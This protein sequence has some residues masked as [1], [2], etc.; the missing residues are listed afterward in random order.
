MRRLLVFTVG[1]SIA[2]SASAA[3]PI[4]QAEHADSETVFITLTTLRNC[5]ITLAPLGAVPTDWNTWVSAHIVNGSPASTSFAKRS[6]DAA[7]AYA[8]PQAKAMICQRAEQG[9][10]QMYADA[11]A[12]M[13][14][15]KADHAK[16]HG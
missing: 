14:R 10:P 8:N 4:V 12:A 11:K 13:S 1:A 6:A 7:R 15:L 16:Y 5:S 3:V 9:A 2:T